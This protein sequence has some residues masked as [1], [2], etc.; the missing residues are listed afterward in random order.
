MLKA[1][2]SSYNLCWWKRFILDVGVEGFPVF[3]PLTAKMVWPFTIIIRDE[4][5]N[6][7][8]TVE[9][10]VNMRCFSSQQLS[11]I[12][13]F[14]SCLEQP[15]TWFSELPLIVTNYLEN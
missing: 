11:A 9:Q 15:K 13:F 4:K 6:N 1:M 5:L 3:S 14:V 10:S 8:P 2:P 7:L 12:I